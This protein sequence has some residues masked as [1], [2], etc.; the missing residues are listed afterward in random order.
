MVLG[1]TVAL[2]SEENQAW[3]SEV[4]DDRA[5]L[6][7]PGSQEELLEAV[8]ATGTPV[9]LVLMAGSAL[10]VDWADEHVPAIVNA[11]YPGEEG[12][13]AVAAVLFGDSNPAGRLPV[14]GYRSVDQLPEFTNYSMVGRTYRY[15]TGEPLYPFG[16]GL[17]YTRFRYSKLTIEPSE[18]RAGSPVEVG[19]EVENS[20]SRAGEEVVQLYLTDVKSSSSVPIRSL[21]GFRRIH[22]APGESQRVEFEVKPEQ[23]GLYKANG[24]HVVEPGEFAVAVGG[25]QPD[26]RGTEENANLVRGRFRLVGEAVK[27]GR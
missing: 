3:E 4:G 5:D 20:G 6:G 26:S 19:V 17:S 25:G 11:W 7:L 1:L 23:M 2:E 10:A 8:H 22:L 24:D 15:F 27:L 18:P 9:V 12:G 14:T 13:N 16:Y 21:Q